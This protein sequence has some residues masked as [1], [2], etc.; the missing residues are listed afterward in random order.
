MYWKKPRNNQLQTWRNKFCD[1]KK[2]AVKHLPT[3]NKWAKAIK[4][5][6]VLFSKAAAKLKYTNPTIA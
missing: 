1:I 2:K 5:I 3:G 6:F 4:V